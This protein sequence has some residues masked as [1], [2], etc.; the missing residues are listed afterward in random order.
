MSFDKRILVFSATYNEIENIRE[1][2]NG[3]QKNLPNSSILIIDDNSPD[4]T[5]EVINELK[6][7]NESLFLIKREKKL[8]LDSAH[9][10][11]FKYAIENN[12]DYL[13]TMDADLSHDPKEL[14]EFINNLKDFPFVIG[15]RY[16]SGGKCLMK[17]FRLIMSKIG[18]KL[19]KIVS[20][21]KSNEF[22]T[23]YRGF[24][25]K[26]L[27]DFDLFNVKTTGYS[28]F[29]ST[30]FELEKKNIEIKEIP[31]TF[32]DRKKGVSKIPKIEIFRTLKNLFFL[33]FNKRFFR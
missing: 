2:I 15:S 33:T 21:I 23:S 13:I 8:G 26:N 17:G 32:Y 11:A 29:M 28:F 3:I 19:I 24:D 9:R 12:F 16:V 1:L 14:P 20:G 4:K 27:K 31:I 5:Q 30:L 6:K 7:E 18:N 10:T 25:I 22:T